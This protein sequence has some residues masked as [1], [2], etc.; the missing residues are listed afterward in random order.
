MFII[1]HL[2]FYGHHWIVILQPLQNWMFQLLVI[3][4]G[5]MALA[6]EISYSCA[7]VSYFIPL[8]NLACRRILFDIIFRY[9]A[10]VRKFIRYPW[11]NIFY[12][13]KIFVTFLLCNPFTNY[14]ITNCCNQLL[15][16]LHMSPDSLA[17]LILK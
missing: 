16:Q 12:C 11:I 2:N 5:R 8:N 10:L 9:P 14:I 15:C 6:C 4:C 17:H 7:V 13:Y 1:P 3:R